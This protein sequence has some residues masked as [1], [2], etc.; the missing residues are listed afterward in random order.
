ME[1]QP[2]ETAPKDG[3]FVLVALYEWNDPERGFV[4]E[5]AKWDGEDW[6][7]EAYPIYPPKH[8]CPITPPPT[9]AR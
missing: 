9:Q 4:Y 6:M 3:T 5:V 1:W 2:I 7:S 8:W